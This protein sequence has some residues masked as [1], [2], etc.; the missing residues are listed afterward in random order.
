M[1]V[2]CFSF[3]LPCNSPTQGKCSFPL[4]H[5]GTPALLS[6]CKFCS[7]SWG[8]PGDAV[9]QL[10]P[11]YH[12]KHTHLDPVG[13]HI[14]S[15][16]HLRNCPA[17]V[18]HHFRILG[19]YFW[20]WTPCASKLWLTAF[21]SNSV[22]SVIYVL[23]VWGMCHCSQPLEITTEAPRP[24]KMRKPK[25]RPKRGNRDPIL[26]TSVSSI[27]PELWEQMQNSVSEK[28]VH[29]SSLLKGLWGC[30]TAIDQAKR[31]FITYLFFMVDFF[32]IS[33]RFGGVGDCL[34]SEE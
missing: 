5:L 10:T 23:I 30:F 16:A 26:K 25:T 33:K 14:P 6:V 24:L 21:L 2:Y 28:S 3:I 12:R 20:L 34:S 7:P 11:H 19:C 17:S 13:E 32:F 1:L 9:W 31:S 18:Q 8:M 4:S 29:I 22:L 15:A 27:Q